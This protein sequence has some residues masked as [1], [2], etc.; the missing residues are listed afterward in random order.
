MCWN[1]DKE[2]AWGGG[3]SIKNEHE[4]FFT[5]PE[6]LEKGE[7]EPSKVDSN[8]KIDKVPRLPRPFIYL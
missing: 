6:S 8:L 4:E 2:L 5:P 1:G 7:L 3:T